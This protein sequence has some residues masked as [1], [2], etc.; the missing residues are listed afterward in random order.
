MTV[1]QWVGW[2]EREAEHVVVLSNRAGTETMKVCGLH[3]EPARIY[4][5]RATGTTDTDAS[6]AD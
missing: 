1:C 2:C 4:G 3:L 5:Y 6:P